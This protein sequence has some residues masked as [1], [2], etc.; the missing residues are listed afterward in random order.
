MDS[1]KMKQ[2]H[3]KQIADHCGQPELEAML[4]D[5]RLAYFAMHEAEKVL[6]VASEARLDYA[7]ELEK[8]NLGPTR[9]FVIFATAAQRCEAF[10]K[11]IGKWEEGS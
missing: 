11:T 10:L 5:D 9:E 3:A 2:E 4:L 6:G 8:L 1:L 7:K